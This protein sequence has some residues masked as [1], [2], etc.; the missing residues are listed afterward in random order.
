MADVIIVLGMHRSGTSA[1][2]FACHQLGVGPGRFHGE[3][4]QRAQL[5]D[6]RRRWLPYGTP[7]ADYTGLGFV[8]LRQAWMRTHAPS[9]APGQWSDLDARISWW[10]YQ[11]HM[12]W[13]V[14]YPVVRHHHYGE[15]YVPA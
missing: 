10:T 9:W 13:H 11:L 5:P 6:G 3:L 12:R 4:V 2:M 1:A 15:G 8:R 14:H 7:W